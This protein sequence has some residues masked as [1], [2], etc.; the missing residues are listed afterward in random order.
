MK[1]FINLAGIRLSSAFSYAMISVAL[2]GILFNNNGS[3]SILLLVMSLPAILFSKLIGGIFDKYKSSSI[4]FIIITIVFQLIITAVMLITGVHSGNLF[5]Y[6]Y[7]LFL[8]QSFSYLLIC[9]CKLA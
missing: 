1:A 3:I 4:T 8:L 5:I 2:M 6:I 9:C 7:S